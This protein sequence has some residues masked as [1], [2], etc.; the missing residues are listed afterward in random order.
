VKCERDDLFRKT[1]NILA[2][3]SNIFQKLLNVH[4]FNVWLNEIQT[5]GQL[6]P[7]EVAMT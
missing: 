5:A 6:V 4:G 3:W 2:G 1:H 7:Y